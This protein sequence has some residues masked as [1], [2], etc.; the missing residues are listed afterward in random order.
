MRILLANKYFY[1]RGGDCIYTIELHNLLKQM[2]HAVA[3]FSMNHEENYFNEYSKYWPK[4]VDYGS[5]NV[6]NF[7]EKTI[8]P[9]G[10]HEVKTKFVSLIKDFRP[11]VI[12]LNNIHTQISP[13]IAKIAFREN[14]PV[15]WT[16]HD[17][18]LICPSYHLL[19][20]QTPCELCLDNKANVVIHKCIKNN[21]IASIAGYIEAK[22]WST[23]SLQKYTNVFISPS[24]FLKGKM[25]SGGFNSAS[26]HVLP[27][28]LPKTRETSGFIPR[29]NYYCYIGR[30]SKEKGIETLL[31]AASS[32]RQFPLKIIGEGPLL[33]EM[34][35]KYHAD[36]I[37]F[38]GYKK[39]EEISCILS[40][41]NFMVIPSE[42]Y[43]NNPL[44]AIESLTQG[45]PILGANIGGIPEIIEENVN[46]VLFTPGDVVGLQEKIV[47]MFSI[48]AKISSSEDIS[49]RARNKYSQESYYTKLYQIYKSVL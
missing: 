8:R 30:I 36:H 29:Q 6:S 3:V 32:L 38:L 2:G 22:K 9:V 43:E 35:L 12:H 11:D 42:W 16:L 41:A 17:Y 21:S 49:A 4:N 20:N 45:T 24:T 46:G 10:S 39:W 27:N 25:V 14:I 47:K 37:N 23:F 7:L 15:V 18:K 19:R 34:K 48:A 31:K 1:P 26:I 5:F 13:I 33:E 40:A 28:F 44:S